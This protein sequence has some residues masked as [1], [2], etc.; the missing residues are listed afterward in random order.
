MSLPEPDE[1]VHPIVLGSLR[2]IGKRAPQALRDVERMGHQLDL[3]GDRADA[4]RRLAFQFLMQG[5]VAGAQ[6]EEGH[7]FDRLP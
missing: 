3:L 7:G 4:E 1:L 2:Q 5:L 6:V